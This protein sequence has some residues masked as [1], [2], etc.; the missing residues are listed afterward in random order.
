MIEVSAKLAGQVIN[1]PVREGNTLAAGDLI[2]QID[3]RE[4]RLVLREL[5]AE[6]MGRQALYKKVEAQVKRVD[7]QTGGHLQAVLS[8]LQRA[9]A[10]LVSAE[11]NLQFKRAE[12]QRA[13]SLLEKQIIPRQSWE[14]SRNAMQQ[15]EQQ[16]HG[17]QAQVD[18][19]KAAVVEAEAGQTELAVLAQ[20]LRA[21]S[22]DKERNSAQIARQNVVIENLRITAPTGVFT[23]KSPA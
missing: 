14:N 20:E 16:L 11:S 22:Y 7:Q 12:W 13:Q 21:I 3:D 15:A 23:A 1:F 8:Q 18:S 17:A 6:L 4:A 2:A 19:A 9:R 10:E 5:K